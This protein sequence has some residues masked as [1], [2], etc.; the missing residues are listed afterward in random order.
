MLKDLTIK[1]NSNIIIAT[2][3]TISPSLT[4]KSVKSARQ[5]TKSTAT[6]G[7]T[8]I[9]DTLKQTCLNRNLPQAIRQSTW[10]AP[11]SST[12]GNGYGQ[13]V[14]EGEEE[15]SLAVVDERGEIAL[16]KTISGVKKVIGGAGGGGG[17]IKKN[18]ASRLPSASTGQSRLFDQIFGAAIP[19]PSTVIPKT[20]TAKSSNVLVTGNLEVLD[21]PS[22]TL[23]P[24]RLL[25]KSMLGS[26]AVSSSVGIE[27]EKEVEKRDTVMGNGDKEVKDGEMKAVV[28]EGNSLL[29]E[30]LRT[31]LSI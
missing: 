23:P 13:K 30:I 19:S 7:A 12:H 22:H 25:W 2:E 18:L 21:A 29:E 6:L 11:G 16:V 31:K 1:P 15:I 5:S 26:F 10:F 28:V 17:E 27:V 20:P 4:S 8:F 14:V 9:I 24:A 3:S